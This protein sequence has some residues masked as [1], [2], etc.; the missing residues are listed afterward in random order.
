MS[1]TEHTVSLPKTANK[2]YPELAG[3]LRAGRAP[4]VR[5]C[6]WDGEGCGQREENTG[7]REVQAA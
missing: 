6:D 1:I 5:T 4:C 2:G 7:L 3:L